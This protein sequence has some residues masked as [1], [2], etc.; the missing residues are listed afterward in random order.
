MQHVVLGHT[1][2]MYSLTPVLFYLPNIL[3]S[4][5][6]ALYALKIIPGNIGK[7]IFGSSSANTNKSLMAVIG[8]PLFLNTNVIKLDVR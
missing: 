7:G 2:H 5:D 3:P 1:D 8:L 6:L 4:F